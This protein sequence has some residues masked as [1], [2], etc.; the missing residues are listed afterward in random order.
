MTSLPPA[1]ELLHRPVSAVVSAYGAPLSVATRDDGQHFD[2][3]AGNTPFTAIVDDDGVVHAIDVA[4][5]SGETYDTTIDAKTYALIGG[6]TTSQQAYDALH[7]YA[8]TDGANYRVFRRNADTDVVLVFDPA[9]KLLSHVVTGDR[10]ALLRLGYLTDPT[11][12]QQRFPFTAPKLRRSSVSAGSGT[13]A[14]VLRLDI[15][16]GGAVKDVVVVVPSSDPAFDAQVA[17][18]LE[19]D[20]Y[21]PAKLGGRNI[22]ASVYREVRH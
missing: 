11:P 22:G 14:T 17:K 8:E 9:T 12:I 5:A 16:T 6:K 13:Q 4:P 21:V 10:G 3:A 1:A 15:T 18:K 20:N 7:N 2:F 19:G